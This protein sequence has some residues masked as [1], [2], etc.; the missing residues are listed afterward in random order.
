M[1]FAYKYRIILSGIFLFFLIPHASAQKVLKGKV[2]DISSGNALY[3]TKI[4][5]DNSPNEYLSDID[6][7]FEIPFI[8]TSMRVS[9]SQYTFRSK[10]IIFD[11]SLTDSMIHVQLVKNKFFE[12]ENCS[13]REGMIVIKKVLY[14]RKENDISN[15]KHL[16][17]STY[18]KATLTPAR[19][20]FANRKMEKISKIFSFRFSSFRPQ[21][22]F[23]ILESYTEKKI[24]NKNVHK[25]EIRGAKSTILDVPSLFIQ[26]T[27][28]QSF[29]PYDNF[30][31]VGGKLFVSPLATHTFNRY[32]FNVIDTIYSGNDTIFVVK[33][34]PYPKKE[35]DGLKGLFYI[36]TKNYGIQHFIARPAQEKKLRMTVLQS[37]KYYPEED[38]WFY[39]RTKTIAEV[40]KS[41]ESFIAAL[42][43]YV[44][45]VNPKS[46]HP[47]KK[48]NEVILEYPSY[49]SKQNDSFWI[50]KRR[51]P[52]TLYDSNTYV[53]YN[54][55]DQKKYIR[56]TL[57]FGE[58]L[59]Y[60]VIEYNSIDL[61]LNRFID[62]N[63]VEAVRVGFGAHTNDQFSKQFK[64]GGYFGYGFRD[65]ENKYGV[66]AS[67]RMRKMP[68]TITSAYSRDLREAGGVFFP[69]HRYQYSSEG[70]RRIRLLIMDMV[71]EWE[72]AVL[73]HP[74]KFVD[75][76]T[77]LNISSHETTYD[78]AYR[79]V[80][81]NEFNF[82]EIR[83]GMRYAY[84]EQFIK[85]LNRQI[86]IRRDFPI[87]YFQFSKGI[88]SFGGE[89]KYERYDAKLEYTFSVLDWGKTGIQ[90]TGGI[91]TGDPPYSKL[92][93]NNGSL[94]NPS[95]VIHNTFETM[96]YNEFLSDRYI[97]LYLSHN[98]GRMYF[99][100]QHIRPSLLLLHNIG[101]G[102]LR[103]P[104]YHKEI[105]FKTMEKGY[106]ESG[107]LIDDILVIKITG[108]KV[109]MGAGF[110]LRYGPYRIDGF[111]NNIVVKFA[112]KFGL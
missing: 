19:I 1:K 21:Q 80:A 17:Y 9:F 42:D 38:F 64:T 53:Y 62:F 97:A 22:H 100:S 92:Y 30:I 94:K 74:L 57:K 50:E 43:N 98:F 72:S 86:S 89:Y 91:V 13:S 37:Y 69:F 8:D 10:E 51:A 16:S 104:E 41:G 87:F 110:F 40:E 24:Y 12:M 4:R 103:H 70:L 106:V 36:N 5:I 76:K 35:F 90:L 7:N 44:F 48:F 107:M 95:V 77:S 67:F 25:E 54:S 105:P 88:S 27:Q 15:R 65:Q 49:A 39:D 84:G 83:T 63:R 75:I 31:N 108:L 93:N 56:R 6:G 101:I 55:A 18:N 23:L 33:F 73:F 59:Y 61:D 112:L 78:Y 14:N 58:H 46:Y 102:S 66:D 99:K 26:T 32:A 2:I 82:T 109:G 20:D 45:N 85:L 71:R 3:F 79:D 29:S 52:L 28:I 60:G 68:V 96:G 81:G 34:N 47:K 11:S 111:E